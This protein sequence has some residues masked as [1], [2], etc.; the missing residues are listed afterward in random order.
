MQ[1]RVPGLSAQAT[2]TDCE[3]GQAVVV[4]I[5][6]LLTDDLDFEVDINYDKP[7]DWRDQLNTSWQVQ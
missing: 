6:Q 1:R 4:S 2:A 7:D 5:K 3:G